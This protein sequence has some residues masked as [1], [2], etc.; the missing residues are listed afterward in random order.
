MQNIEELRIKRKKAL[1]KQKEKKKKKRH[2]ISLL[3]R[4]P[5][6]LRRLLPEGRGIQNPKRKTSSYPRGP[7]P[8]LPTLQWAM[9]NRAAVPEFEFRVSVC[10]WCVARSVIQPSLHL[11][12]PA[13]VSLLFRLGSLGYN[14]FIAHRIYSLG[15]AGSTTVPPGVSMCVCVYGHPRAVVP[16]STMVLPTVPKMHGGREAC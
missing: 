16:C 3:S 15:T 7:H 9:K 2:K 12:Y 6:A 8:P 5:A 4:P 11:P 10:C 13:H 1:K 14:R